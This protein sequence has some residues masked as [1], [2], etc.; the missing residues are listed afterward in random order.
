MTRTTVTAWSVTRRAPH[1]YR[2]G[3]LAAPTGPRLRSALAREHARE[4]F[5]PRDVRSAVARVRS[6]AS[7]LGVEADV[8]RGGVDVGGAELDHVWAV[9]DGHVVDVTMPLR[10]TAFADVLRTYVAGDV[11]DDELDSV[12]HGYGFEWRVVGEFPAPLRYVGLPVWGQRD[13]AR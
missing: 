8:V 2:S 9:V 7:G 6:V 5:T 13:G 11:D 1:R 10:A 4:P 3:E 12:A